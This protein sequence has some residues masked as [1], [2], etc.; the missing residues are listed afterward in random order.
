MLSTARNGSRLMAALL[1]AGCSSPAALAPAEP[2]TATPVGSTAAQAG[3]AEPPSP[4][5][6]CGRAPAAAGL[7]LVR[8]GELQTP[9]LLTLPDGYDGKSPVPLVFAFHG[10]TRTHQTLH[11]SDASG[12][13]DELGRRYA[14]AYVKSLGPG[15]DQPSD[16]LRI[17]DALYT[18]LAGN[19]CIDTEQVFALGHSSGAAFSELL[20]C[21]RGSRLRGVAAVAGALVLPV[22]A[23]R[24]AMLLIHGQRD[25]VLP[26]SRGRAGRDHFAAVNGCSRQTSASGAP[27]CV[28]Y[29]GCEPSLPVE[30]CEHGEATY[31]NTNHGWPSFAS[32]EIARFFAGLGRV[33]RPG[34]TALIRNESF[35]AGSEPWQ[36]GFAGSAKGRSSVTNGALCT[37]LE[38]QG[39]NPWD[40]QVQYTG[41]KLEQG[42]EY[43]IDYRLWTSAASDV[44]VKLGLDAAPWSEYWVN[45]VVATPVPQ[46]LRSSFTLSDPAPGTLAFG[47]QFAGSAAAQLPLTLCID[48]VSV[49][50]APGP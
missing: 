24:S 8:A 1:L 36:V 35:A 27:G 10:R 47:F 28:S 12:L 7:Q 42:R 13:A 32:A 26:V 40:A 37:T 45:S 44:R 38:S 33:P 46:R 6:G 50:L 49:A 22:C 29:V 4:S 48:D 30:W 2:K 5:S 19:Y 23:E 17:F 18:H 14:V 11:D 25:A 31:E 39:E 41:L 9:Y 43:A 20:A 3:R 21:E 15:F 16:N 34:G